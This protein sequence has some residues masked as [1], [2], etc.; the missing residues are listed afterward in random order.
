M[1]KIVRRTLFFTLFVVQLWQ[2]KA[3]HIIGGEITYQCLGFTNNNPASNSRDYRFTMRI[4]RDCQGSGAGFDS[5][6]N[7]AFTASVSI[8]LG[9]SPIPFQTLYLAAPTSTPI[10]PN[11]GNPCLIVPNNVCVQQGVYVFPVIQLPISTESYFISYQRCCRNNTISNILNPGGSGATYTIELTP[12]A[13]LVGNSSPVFSGYPPVVLCAGQPF[14]ASQAAIDPDG[15]QLVYE[16]CTPLLGGGLNFNQPLALNGLAPDP[17]N[18]PPYNGVNFIAPAFTSQNPLGAQANLDIGTYTGIMTGMP[19]IQGQFVVGICVSEYRNGVLLSTVR[20][21]FQFNVSTCTPTVVADMVADSSSSQSYYYSRCGETELS[22]MNESYQAQFIEQ[23]RWEFDINGQTEVFNTW[24][25]TVNF[26]GPGRYPGRLL[27]NPGVQNCGDTA[28][29]EV[30]IY[31]G[32][33]ADFGFEY[34]TCRASLVQFTDLSLTGAPAEKWEWDFGD[35]R[36]SNSQNPQN[37]YPSPGTRNVSLKVTDTNRCSDVASKNVNYFPAPAL[38]IVSPSETESCAPTEVYFNNLSSPVDPTYS[39]QWDFGDGSTSA[40]ISP[41]HTYVEA[42]VY[43]VKL[44]VTSPINC[45]T[46]TVFKQLVTVTPA[47]IADFGFSPEHSDYFNPTVQFTDQSI[48]AWRWYWEFAPGQWSS[49]RNPAYTYA[50]T[51]LHAVRLVVTHISGCQDSITKYVD[52]APVTTFH[53]PNAFTPNDDSVNDVF[54][55]EGFLP[56][57]KGYSM[58]VWNRWGELVFETNNPEQG[59]NGR[60]NNSGAAAIPGVYIL[61]VHI[62][63]PRGEQEAYKGFVTLIR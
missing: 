53:L 22:F 13:Q 41:T 4:Y 34:D 62:T 50:D 44:S 32:I 19:T 43:D 14:S 63:G 15:D 6:P 8:F 28:T 5:A 58:R 20:R 24:D 48:D 26:P 35:G 31:P 23:Y 46:D 56:G 61:E 38:L 36:T 40:A 57:I 2:L 27:L 21:D 12:A 29:I 18:P 49:L 45:T 42:G 11:P 3:A 9:N 25:V 16:L 55:G 39:I 59:W 30:N 47:P 52:I 1:K 60:K 51:G 17:D 7:G 54:K 10:D 33:E 37:L